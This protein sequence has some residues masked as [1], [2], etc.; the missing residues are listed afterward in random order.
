MQTRNEDDAFR[1][2][3]SRVDTIELLQDERDEHAIQH[4]VF[5]Q[6]LVERRALPVT[7]RAELARLLEDGRV[8]GDRPFF[9]LAEILADFQDQGGDVIEQRV[10]GEHL[11]RID[12]QQVEQALEPSRRER[13]CSINAFGDQIA[14][15]RK[16][17][18][19]ND[20]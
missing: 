6:D 4:L 3:G 13:A 2:R 5:P 19:R 15:V 11:A 7:Q 18:D 9:G 17:H 16:N 10:R 12:G 20:D 14:E 8:R 1:W